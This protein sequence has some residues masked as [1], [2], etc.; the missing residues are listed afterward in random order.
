MTSHPRENWGRRGANRAA[1]FGANRAANFGANR[2][3]NLGDNRAANLGGNRA[4][5]LGA[6]RR[7][8]AAGIGNGNWSR[9]DVLALGTKGLAL[10]GLGGSL[11]EL[12]AGC[13]KPG[14]AAFH[15][16]L[17][18]KDN[19]VTWPI[20]DGNES[21]KSG[22][23]P[24]SG[25]PTLQ[26][27]NWVAYINTAVCESFCKKYDCNYQ[28]TTFNTMSEAIAKMQTGELNFDVFMGVT[29][30]VLGPLIEAKLLQ[31]LNHSYIPNIEQAWK[32]YDNPFYDQHWRYT[33]PYTIYTT[34]ISWRKDLV[35]G[36]EDFENPWSMPWQEKYR[37]RVAILDDYREG[38]CLGLMKQGIY[39]LNTTSLD[40]ITSSYNE[41][42]DLQRLVDV[43]IDN[44][45]YT[46][47]PDGQTWIHHAWSGD[48]AAAQYYMPKGTPVEVVGYWFPADGKG[49]VA[50]DTNTIPKSAQNPVLAHLFLNYLLDLDIAITNISFNGY[51][52]P[53]YGVTPDKLIEEKILPKSLTSTVV[54]PSYFD[55]GIEQL[56]LPPAT[57][58][59][60]ELA[61]TEFGG[62]L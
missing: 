21:I 58:N 60:W 32:V 29:I 49:P 27:Y 40:Q 51:M 23:P 12:L 16:P 36:P 26:I 19:P 4:A 17:P 11:S 22:L 50:N 7:A 38:I 57:N 34:G 55:N 47:I 30:D 5:N 56:G 35:E 28:I 9:R 44:N 15:L 43:L 3:A 1:N 24:E 54:L 18:R 52:Q 53:I 13:Q 8:R 33:A 39:N 14:D 62:G 46:E 6:N 10:A 41:L 20:F 42:Q 61:W 2:G 25:K 59:A 31:P 48:M 37:G 45:D